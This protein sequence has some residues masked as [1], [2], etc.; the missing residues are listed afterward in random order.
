MN[1]RMPPHLEFLPSPDTLSKISGIPNLH[2]S[3]MEN[4]IPNPINSKHTIFMTLRKW[5][6]L[7][8]NHISLVSCHATLDVFGF[9]FQVMAVSEKRENL[10]AQSSRSASGEVGLYTSISLNA[11]KKTDQSLTIRNTRLFRWRSRIFKSKHILCCCAYQQSSSF[12]DKF[13][14]HVETTLPNLTRQNEKCLLWLHDL[15]SE[16]SCVWKCSQYDL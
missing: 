15:L 7:V 6:C 5:L 16:S 11:V 14:E 13:T 8:R 3:N 4:N 1:F 10:N 2:N 12:F 9:P